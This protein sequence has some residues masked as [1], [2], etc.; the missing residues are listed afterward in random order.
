MNKDI[1][2]CTEKGKELELADDIMEWV[3]ANDQITRK[4]DI[5]YWDWIGGVNYY[6]EIIASVESYPNGQFRVEKDG[7]SVGWFKNYELY[8]TLKEVI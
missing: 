1:D 4:G 2:Y 6:G 7:I 5:I 3:G 8:E